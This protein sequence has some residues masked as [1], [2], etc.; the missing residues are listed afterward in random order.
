[1]L[2]NVAFDL[3]VAHGRCVGVWLPEA[4]ADIDRLARS[5]LEASEREY[6]ESL[7]AP[8]RRR[9]WV[10]GRVAL[11]QA[12]ACA[13]IDAPPVL[14]DS[15]GAPTLPDGVA[16][17]ISHKHDLAVA[18][19]ARATARIGV[20]IEVDEARAR[21]ISS[22]VLTDD[23]AVEIESMVGSARAREVLLRFSAK[24]AIYKALDPF[25]R[26]YVGFREVAV[27]PHPDGGARVTARLR[28]S[29]GPFAIDVRWLRWER[30]VLT[31]ARVTRI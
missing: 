14:T 6:A 25:V 21:D 11:R 26:R 30:F 20:D 23:E 19:V 2:P 8:L 17:S 31:T 15:R 22:K 18:L 3:N 24:E 28:E 7:A 29:E 1:M 9:T 5:V 10:G 16:G 12:L 4:P 27:T 13:R